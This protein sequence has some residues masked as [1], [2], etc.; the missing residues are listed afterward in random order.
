MAAPAF[1][2]MDLVVIIYLEATE[3]VRSETCFGKEC[4]ET[5]MTTE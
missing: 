2:T 5:M 3:K 1:V 4:V